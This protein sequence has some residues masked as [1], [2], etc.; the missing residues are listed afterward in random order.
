MSRDLS[1]VENKLLESPNIIDVTKIIKTYSLVTSQKFTTDTW[2][3]NDFDDTSWKKVKIPQHENIG[4]PEFK[5]GNYIYYRILIPKAAFERLKKYKSEV[6]L[7]VQEVQ[8][9]KFEI[10]INGK[11]FRA[12]TPNTIQESLDVIPLDETKDNLVCFKGLIESGDYG[13]YSRGKILIGKTGELNQLFTAS[14]K[15][16]AVFS[17]IYLFCKGSILVVF[18]LLFMVLNV[19]KFFEKSLLFIMFVIMEDIIVGE[20]LSE[21]LT[22]YH[23]VGIYNLTNVGITISLFLFLAE[24]LEVK[25]PKSRIIIF[26]LGLVLISSAFTLDLLKLNYFFNFDLYLKF[27][28]AVFV[29][30]LIFFLPRMLKRE[31]VLASIVCVSLGLTLWSSLFAINVGFNLKT[32]SNLL[33]FFGVAYQTFMLFRKD[34]I[35]LME[36]EKDVAIGKTAA[37]L[38][39]DVRRPLEQ[40]NLIL[41]KISSG[42]SSQEFLRVAKQDVEFSITSVDN[43]INDIMNFTRTQKLHLKPVSF[44]NVLSKSIKQVLITKPDLNL[45]LRYDFK[46]SFKILGDE[47]RLAGLL[48]N[49]IANAAEAIKEIGMTN[50][51]EICFETSEHADVFE[52][53]MSNSGPNIPDSII[54]EIFKPLFTSGKVGGTGLGL[55]SVAKIVKDHNGT[56]TVENLDY[57][58]LFTVKFKTSTEFDDVSK[59]A[60]EGASKNYI[61]KPVNRMSIKS[62]EGL[63]IFLLDDESYVYEHLVE[64]VKELPFEV[65][66]FYAN[67]FSQAEKMVKSKRFDLY[68]LDYDLGDNTG[69]DFYN[70]SI[71]HLKDEVFLITNQ[72]AEGLTQNTLSTFNNP[73]TIDSLIEMCRAANNVRKKILLVEDSKIITLGWIMYHGKHNICTVSNPV[74]ALKFLE[75][76]PDIDV[77]VL[78]YHFDGFEMNGEELAEI[79]NTKFPRLVI[80]I[81]SSIEVSDSR[82][83]YLRKG[84][85]RLM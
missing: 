15:S 21:Y 5:E 29:S 66:L 19:A 3:Q 74:D 34:Q 31:K 65:E 30:V 43:H 37:V 11:F 10:F 47:S 61:Y 2:T 85:Y 4:D 71:S 63:R 58:V 39:H 40:M 70:R 77:C 36:Q 54:N 20:Y 62:N 52:F 8:L 25:Y 27:W 68:I 48:V 79:I 32:F 80:F 17:L 82:F 55:A 1:N 81:S 44:Y 33:I 26:S 42:E 72:D 12:Y 38:A 46:A 28:N 76:N 69:L 56:I 7:S 22:L 24:V 64:L 9:K 51:G 78:D 41:D 59:Y 57:G 53:K 83:Q 6:S 73:I 50:E 18:A 16:G 75:T 84:V 14:Y 45:T 35:Q 67:S 60:F 49:L 13:I 23:Q